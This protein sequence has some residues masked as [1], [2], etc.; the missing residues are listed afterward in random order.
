VFDKLGWEKVPVS[1]T[2]DRV[3]YVTYMDPDLT[4][5]DWPDGS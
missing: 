4:C 1:E 2:S 3:H 5:S